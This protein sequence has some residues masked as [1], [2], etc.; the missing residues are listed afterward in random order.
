MS[1]TKAVLLQGNEA[2]VMGAIK[3]GMK[4]FGG[5]PITPSSEIAEQSSVVLPQV[6]GRF[7]QMEDE[8]ASMASVIGAS[9]AGA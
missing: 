5:Y 1:D 7:I 6:G 4:F 3:A 8:I 2:C 9:L